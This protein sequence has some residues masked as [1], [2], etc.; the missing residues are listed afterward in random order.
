MKKI[1]LVLLLTSALPAL[2]QETEGKNMA[3]VNLSAFALKGFGVQYERQIGKRITVGLGYSMIP[4]A[5]IA[6][7]SVV[8]NAIDD[9][10]VNVGDFRLGTSI[11]TPEFRY[12]LGK[13]GAFHG[14]YFAPYARIGSYKIAGPVSYT[15]STNVKKTA[16][17]DGKLN[18]FTGGL[19][20]G[21]S[22]QLSDKFY[23][24]WWI[25]GASYGSATG[26]LI[27][28]TPLNPAEQASLKRELDEIEVVGTEI[29][30]EV[31]SN[32]ATVT[33]SG[34]IAGTRGLGIN[35]GIR[36]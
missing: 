5:T 15:S 2:S 23:L 29:K 12:Y 28:A 36:F 33:T 32:G 3:K 34:S 8:E 11:F 24:D 27:A 9:P 4:K 18:T 10:D 1:T 21:S 19:M 31:N 13:K 14:F 16:V 17:F 25:I 26:N 7:K 35:F 30:S 6:F 22:W 20:I